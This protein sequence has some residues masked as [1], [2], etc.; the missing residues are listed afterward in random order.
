MILLLLGY[1][2]CSGCS[3]S[4]SRCYFCYQG[5]G[6]VGVF[7][8]IGGHL[9][10][11]GMILTQKKYALDLL[12]RVNMENCNP[13]ITPLAPSETLSR[14][15]GTLL[16]SDDSHRYRSV[17][18]GLQYLTLTR[19]DIS[20]A[21]NKVCQFLSQPTD[22]HWES[23]KRILRYVKGRRL[24]FE[25]TS[26]HQQSSVS[27]LTQIGP[28]VW[29]IGVLPAGLQYLLGQI[30]FLGALRSNQQSRGQVQRQNTKHWLMTLLKLYG[31]TLFS[32]SLV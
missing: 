10:F 15:S 32:K 1:V 13:A 31:L 2:G 5:L 30:L 28:V 3:S 17:V 27:S 6:Q 29:M 11:R 18:G 25:F 8:W 23:V 4:L 7:S 26:H 16:N 19:P 21:V 24:V 20:F 14:S 12:H 9:Q 22:V